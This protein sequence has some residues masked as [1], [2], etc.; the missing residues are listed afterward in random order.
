MQYEVEQ[1]FPVSDLPAVAAQ[2]EELGA[3]FSERAREVDYYYGHPA[4]DFAATDEALRLRQVSD[5]YYLTYKGPKI[6]PTTKTRRE[7]ELPL[8]AE[9]RLLA[10]WQS[11]L[12]AL[13]FHLVG[14]V[15]KDRRRARLCWEGRQVQAT[16]DEVPALGCFVELEITVPESDL[17]EARAC[18]GSLALRLGL[19]ESERRSYLELLLENRGG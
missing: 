1:K 19:R 13:G 12:E 10:Q 16:L 5:Q 14:Q 9:D 2:L 18:I 6:D 8:G 11:L 3:V 7:I 15:I 4:R 17:D